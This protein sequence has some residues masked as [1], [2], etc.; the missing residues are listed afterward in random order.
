MKRFLPCLA[1]LFLIASCSGSV[2]EKHASALAPT[3]RL[4]DSLSLAGGAEA[5]GEASTS[6]HFQ[7]IGGEQEIVV[8]PEK[9]DA[10]EENGPFT[11]VFAN[12]DGEILKNSLCEKGDLPYYWGVPKLESTD[13]F[14]FEF[15]GW[16]PSVEPASR[17]MVYT[18]V[19]REIPRFEV[20]F[21]DGDKVLESGLFDEGST[22]VYSEN[23]MEREP[24]AKYVYD[25]IPFAD[26]ELEPV[27]RDTV[28][29]VQFE[30][31]FRTYEVTFIDQRAV[32]KTV[33]YG[34][35]P[36]V[37]A[38]DD[39][40]FIGYFDQETGEAVHPVDGDVTY[41]AEYS[42]SIEI[43]IHDPNGSSW[44]DFTTR[45]YYQKDPTFILPYSTLG[46]YSYSLEEGGSVDYRPMD[47]LEVDP[48][49]PHDIELYLVEDP[50]LPSYSFKSDYWL[51]GLCLTE[52]D[53]AGLDLGNGEIVLPT[54]ALDSRQIR[55]VVAI[56]NGFTSVV[57]CD[58]PY[59][60]A[61]IVLPADLREIRCD[62]FVNLPLLRGAIIPS[63]IE[64]IESGSFVGAEGMKFHFLLEEEEAA[65]IA[66]E[67][68]CPATSRIT[69]G[70]YAR[71]LAYDGILYRLL[72]HRQAEAVG[73]EEGRE[74]NS[75][76]LP[77]KVPLFGAAYTLTSVGERAFAG[78]GIAEA[79]LPETV[80]RLGEAAFA[81]CARLRSFDLPFAVSEIPDYCFS[82]CASL[83]DIVLGDSIVAI[84][85]H[86]FENS[87][88]HSAPE[89]VYID[90]LAHYL[91][92][93]RL[94]ARLE[95]IG[96]RAFY[97]VDFDYVLISKLA[98][99]LGKQIF[100][101]GEE[102]SSASLLF[103]Q[104]AED[105]LPD[106]PGLEFASGVSASIFGVRETLKDEE[107][108]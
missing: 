56:G 2:P 57:R 65:G 34:K 22:P 82:G 89:S 11:I 37:P 39:E 73:F 50:T 51:G 87:G 97:G 70:A 9:E 4:E 33:E 104:E 61:S 8:P 27:S 58:D 63:S 15:E 54:T 100:A 85:A 76:V 13:E 101:S 84:G 88:L 28:Y 53:F 103:E 90:G 41:V 106:Y 24:T 49:D 19:Y 44:N 48:D 30:E 26:G 46:K 91:S 6:P 74:M 102:P 92:L 66:E 96:D 29:E 32:R 64:K 23:S 93:Y 38:N 52:A 43:R 60:V 81:D 55:P 105:L 36:A 79:S 72:P 69:Y 25:F 75:L 12:P 14:S 31:S 21:V 18:A 67:G 78:E 94:P 71:K 99:R 80:S 7:D 68:W 10:G 98:N 62:S 3:H 40:A 77:E 59:T 47:V 42:D 95:S 107:S 5:V 16:R 20:S 83:D 45:C 108:E 17:D 1:L 35:M 86:A